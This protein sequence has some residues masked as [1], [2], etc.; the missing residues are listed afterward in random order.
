MA[1]RI[2]PWLLPGFF[3]RSHG[4]DAG[5]FGFKCNRGGGFLLDYTFGFW[6]RTFLPGSKS[7]APG[8]NV[9]NG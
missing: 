3:L 4:G 9:V 1:K 2:C 8:G 5:L 6:V 7:V